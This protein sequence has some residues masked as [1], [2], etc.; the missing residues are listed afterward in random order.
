MGNQFVFTAVH[1][2]LDVCK[3]SVH[4]GINEVKR[5]EALLTTFS[6]DSVTAKINRY[7]GIKPVIVPEEVFQLIERSKKISDITQGAFDITY[8]SVDKKLWNFDTSMI[9]LP[10]PIAAKRNVKLVNYNNIE[11]DRSVF[12]VMLKQKGMRIGFGGIGKGYAAEMAKNK[13]L[14]FGIKDGVVNAA[15]DLTAW[16]NQ[17]DDA[18]WTVGIADPDHKNQLFSSFVISD[19][20][21]ATSGDY[22]KYVVIDGIK[23]SHTIDP[24]T[25][26]PAKG[27]KSVTV[28]CPNAELADALTTPMII[29]GVDAGLYMINQLKGVEAVLID[30]DNKIY[31]SK[32]IN[33]IK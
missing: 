23:Y 16:G 26:M 3:Q 21:V 8:G 9:S 1:E 15:G 25:G 11:M 31:H 2:S 7:A 20:G 18:P 13:L 4:E 28:F 32:N 29:L 27:M 17:P 24:K 19:R 5:I 30:S 6:D 33:I 10:D 12:S 14:S 22:E